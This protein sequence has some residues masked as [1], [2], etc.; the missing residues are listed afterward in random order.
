MFLLVAATAREQD[1]NITAP[2][3]IAQARACVCLWHNVA[4]GGGGKGGVR[5]GGGGLGAAP[6]S[7]AETAYGP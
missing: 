2:T 6:M 5:G 4:R 1:S 3:N 7:C